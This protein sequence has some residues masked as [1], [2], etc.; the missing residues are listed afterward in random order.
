MNFESE[1]QINNDKL[2]SQEV[3]FYDTKNKNNINKIGKYDI[4]FQ[5]QNEYEV[6]VLNLMQN[7]SIILCLKKITKKK[8]FHKSIGKWTIPKNYLKLSQKN[9]EA[10]RYNHKISITGC[11]LPPVI[12]SFESMK[13]PNYIIQFLESISILKPTS[14][15]IQLLPSILLG[16]DILTLSKSG[17]GKT[18]SYIISSLLVSINDEIHNKNYG[19]SILIIVPNRELANQISDKIEMFNSKFSQLLKFQIKL[20]LCIGGVDVLPQKMDLDSGV[21]II[22]GTP[23]RLAHLKKKKYLNTNFLKLLVIDE[24]DRLFDHSFN[25]NLN[26]ILDNI[27]SKPQILVFGLSLNQKKQ[28]LITESLFNPIKIISEKYENTDLNVLQNFEYVSETS[29]LFHL[30]TTL[31]KTPPPVIIFCSYKDDID[32]IQEYLLLKGID[33]CSIHSD[34]DQY[35]RSKALKEF[36]EGLKDVLICTDIVSKGLDFKGVEHIINWEFP[37][38]IDYYFTRVGICGKLSEKKGIV[39]TFLKKN[40]DDRLLFDLKYSLI[41]NGQNIPKFLENIQCESNLIE[42]FYCGSIEHNIQSCKKLQIEKQKIVESNI[43]NSVFK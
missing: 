42:C 26:D 23:G 32:F 19:P 11:D 39:T 28:D 24:I 13:F 34:K 40:V 4:S 36:K 41:K 31:Q 22:V 29:K 5:N 1:N 14:L 38:E 20:A 25:D 7:N 12:D 21:H 33:V 17:S 6:E 2:D 18:F 16:R 3:E 27:K 35:V 9:L 15:Q 30:L 10:I 43:K 8:T 37:K